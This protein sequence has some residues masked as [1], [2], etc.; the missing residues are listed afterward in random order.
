M[1]TKRSPR[2]AMLVLLVGLV[3]LPCIS[4]KMQAPIAAF[5]AQ[6]AS[7][8]TFTPLVAKQDT[9][10]NQPLD[11]KLVQPADCVY[12]GAFT[13]PGGDDP[14]LTFAYGGNAMTFNPDSDQ[15]NTDAFPGSLFIMGHERLAYGGLPNGS[16]VAEVSIPVPI[17]SSDIANLPK[18]QFIQGFHNVTAGFFTQLEEIPKVGMQYLNHPDTGP[19][20]HLAWGQH[21]QPEGIASHAWLNATLAKPNMQGVWF[22]GTQSL[23]SVNGYMFDIPP[24]WADAHIAGRYLAT[25]RFRDGGQGGMGPALFAYRPW[26]PDGSAPASGTHLPETTLLL[27]ENAYN[28]DKIERCLNDYQHADE[29]EGGAWIIT[30]SGKSA[31]LFAGNKGTGKKY[32]YGYIHPDNPEKPCVDPASVGQFRACITANG[33]DCPSEDFTGCKVHTSEK[34]WWSSRFDAQFILYDPADLAQVAAGT[35]KS[36]EPQPY[37]SLS[38]EKNLY[39]NPAGIEQNLI[40]TG[41]QRRYKIGPVAYDRNNG[42]LYVLEWFADGPKPVVHVWRIR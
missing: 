42:L 38:I 6:A 12:Q 11:N 39:L 36:W 31:V 22:I 2:H 17:T 40:G 7:E 13:L 24:P 19:K 3:I 16:Q 15:S 41:V 8:P 28:T 9:P 37:A 33:H 32:W 34:G 20:I 14:P 30:P 23:Y 27:Y 5:Q 10:P 29:W 35:M 4:I 1:N 26:L 18:A 25:G 21:L